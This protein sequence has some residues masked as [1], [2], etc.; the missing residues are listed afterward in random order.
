[1]KVPGE[2]SYFLRSK[3]SQFLAPL[4]HEPRYPLIQ[5]QTESFRALTLQLNHVDWPDPRHLA[6]LLHS[7]IVPHVT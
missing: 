4:I 2:A 5:K 3:Q 6:A 1:M 7:K